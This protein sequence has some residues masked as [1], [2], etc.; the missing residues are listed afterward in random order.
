MIPIK[1]YAG[2]AAWP[3]IFKGFYYIC[4]KCKKKINNY[5]DFAD[6][7]MQNIDRRACDNR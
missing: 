6:H 1:I 7:L 3:L 2:A 4:P 5:S